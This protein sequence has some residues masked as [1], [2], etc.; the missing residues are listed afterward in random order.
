[1]LPPTTINNNNINNI[2]PSN[3]NL[4]SDEWIARSDKLR[5][6]FEEKVEILYNAKRNCNILKQYRERVIAKEVSVA[7]GNYPPSFAFQCEFET[8]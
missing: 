7:C 2:T 1:L 3:R 8:N 6:I 5:Q 4:K